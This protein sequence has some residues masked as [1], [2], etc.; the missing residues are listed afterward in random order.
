MTAG[1]HRL[2]RQRRPWYVAGTR[3][4]AFPL[5]VFVA[6]VLAALAG[7]VTASGLAAADPPEATA[8]VAASSAPGRSCFVE[9]TEGLAQR[10][11]GRVRNVD[12]RWGR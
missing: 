5:G 4:P 9:P 3:R 1:R 10:P 8:L 6:T 2:T 12:E 11:A 7:V